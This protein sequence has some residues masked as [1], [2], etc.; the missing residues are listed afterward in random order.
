VDLTTPLGIV[1]GVGSVCGASHV[2]AMPAEEVE[3][4]R[5]LSLSQT[6]PQ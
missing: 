5:V 1:I 4:L 3:I 6:G 2:L